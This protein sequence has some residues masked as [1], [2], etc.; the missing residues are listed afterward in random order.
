MERYNSGGVRMCAVPLELDIACCP[1]SLGLDIPGSM[2]M[3][4][5]GIRSVADLGVEIGPESEPEPTTWPKDMLVLE[6]GMLILTGDCAALL[7]GMSLATPPDRAVLTVRFLDIPEVTCLSIEP[8][9]CR[10]EEVPESADAP[11]AEG[12]GTVVVSRLRLLF[13]FPPSA[14]P[15]K[16]IISS[17]RCACETR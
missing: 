17:S 10:C 8:V 3:L 7:V 9:S 6:L 12:G 1:Y 4:D 14:V 15:F 5:G 11:V 2:C 13:T 16:A